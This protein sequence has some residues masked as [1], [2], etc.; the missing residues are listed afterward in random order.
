MTR[1]ERCPSPRSAT[2]NASPSSFVSL[3]RLEHCQRHIPPTQEECPVSLAHGPPRKVEGRGC[4]FASLSGGYN[5]ALPVQSPPNSATKDS[6]AV[7]DLLDFELE[8]I[9][10]ANNYESRHSP[11]SEAEILAKALGAPARRVLMQAEFRGPETGWRDGHLS[12]SHGFCPPSPSA[13]PTALARSQGL[14]FP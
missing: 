4:I 1:V 9:P 12:T 14:R 2:T 8:Q 3:G 7:T 5:Q 10:V 13:S 6:K 11:K